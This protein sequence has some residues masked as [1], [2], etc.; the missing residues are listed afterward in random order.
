[1]IF[2]GIKL[3]CTISVFFFAHLQSYTLI[4]RR[5][6]LFHVVAETKEIKEMKTMQTTARNRWT[7]LV[8][9]AA[10]E[11]MIL[12]DT[13]IVNIAIGYSHQNARA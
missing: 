6:M 2:N 11:F 12:L 13:S 7:A 1:M 5:D 3:G 10:I 9:L 4:S 8:L